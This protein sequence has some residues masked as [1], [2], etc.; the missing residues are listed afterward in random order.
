MNHTNLIKKIKHTQY[1][2]KK[3]IIVDSKRLE[4]QKKTITQGINQNLNIKFV[5]KNTD[6]N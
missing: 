6:K 5:F 4:K 2:N 1:N 3:I